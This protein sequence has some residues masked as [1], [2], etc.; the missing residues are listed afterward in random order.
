MRSFKLLMLALLIMVVG[1]NATSWLKKNINSIGFKETEK[2]AEE[3]I[4]YSRL[5]TAYQRRQNDVAVKEILWFRKNTLSRYKDVSEIKNA[6]SKELDDRV[7]KIP[8][9]HTEENL[10]AYQLLHRLDPDNSRYQRKVAFYQELL[11]SQ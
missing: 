2:T 4:H 9:D 7:R 8:M 10:E 6:V 11:D 1:D 3:E 5:E